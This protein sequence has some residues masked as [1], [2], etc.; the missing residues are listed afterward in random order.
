MRAPGLHQVPG[1]SSSKV[2][3]PHVQHF[4][5]HSVLVAATATGILAGTAVGA[6]ADSGAAGRTAAA[7]G[8]LAGNLLQA[9]AHVPVN[10]CGNTV[11][12]IGLLNPA[13][14]NHCASTGS[15]HRPPGHKPPGGH[16]P[17]GHKPPGHK[18]PGNHQPPGHKPPGHKPPGHKP[19]GHQPPGHHQPPGDRP[20][21][22]EV[23]GTPG[24]GGGSPAA[25]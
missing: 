10:L 16:Q 25:H 8:V 22:H 13:F 6:H 21:G 3:G 2:E 5:K 9:P 17:P 20:P 24:P 4:V 11:N 12:V 19:P 18:P 1:S 7:P 14:A 15:G 23:P